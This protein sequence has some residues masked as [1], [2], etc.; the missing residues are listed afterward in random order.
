M[1]RTKKNEQDRAID[2][3]EK[4]LVFQLYTLDVTQ[5]RI[6]K[7]VG[8]KTAWVNALVKGIHKGGKSNAN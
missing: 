1:P 5:P 6:A 2:L 7:T 4:M 3:L 8:K